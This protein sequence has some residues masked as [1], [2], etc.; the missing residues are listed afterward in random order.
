LET[1]EQKETNDCM[2][3]HAARFQLGGPNQTACRKGKK[4][5][6]GVVCAVYLSL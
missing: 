5:S 3:R 1:R 4:G 6:G 2:E